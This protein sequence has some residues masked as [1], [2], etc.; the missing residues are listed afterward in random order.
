M[1]LKHGVGLNYP[2]FVDRIF[3]DIEVTPIEMNHVGVK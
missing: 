2:K 1:I 3:E